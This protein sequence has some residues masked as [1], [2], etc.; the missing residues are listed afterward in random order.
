MAILVAFELVF[1]N[2]THSYYNA[3]VVQTYKVRML[4]KSNEWKN[5]LLILHTDT[6]TH[7][8]VHTKI[9]KCTLIWTSWLWNYKFTNISKW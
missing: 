9:Q 3:A 7:T 2:C 4:A 1:Q 8:D 5:T 6:Y